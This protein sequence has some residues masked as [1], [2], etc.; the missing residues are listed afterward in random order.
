MS[1]TET[2]KGKL[3]PITIPDGTT[4]EEYA[5][6][7]CNRLDLGCEAWPWRSWLECLEDHRKIVILDDVIYWVE[8]E[9]LD[10][11]GFIEGTLN[12]DGSIDYFISYYNGGASFTE[13]VE[14]VAKDVL[15]SS[16]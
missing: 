14:V 6:E 11:Y 10:P 12:E 16:E 15:K 7:A 1:E 5:E 3:I 4:L 9:K 8:D 2:H 13:V